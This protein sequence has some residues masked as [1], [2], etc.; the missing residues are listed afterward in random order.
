MSLEKQIPGLHTRHSLPKKSNG[1]VEKFIEY[2]VKANHALEVDHVKKEIHKYLKDFRNCPS[3]FYLEWQRK[4]QVSHPCI[5]RGVT[6]I[7]WMSSRS[8]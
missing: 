7:L 2:V 3:E 1:V 6:C 8:T 5:E 4:I